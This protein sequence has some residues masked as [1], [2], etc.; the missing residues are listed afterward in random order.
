MY[1]AGIDILEPAIGAWPFV[2]P[3]VGS[4]TGP[5]TPTVVF[6]HIGP[7]M[8]QAYALSGGP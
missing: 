4:V 1:P 7:D 2:P 5:G 3:W 8:Y 6:L